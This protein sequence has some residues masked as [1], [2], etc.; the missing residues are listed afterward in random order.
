MGLKTSLGCKYLLNVSKSLV[1]GYNTYTRPAGDLA[2]GGRGRRVR[3]SRS[4][5]ATDQESEGSLD[6]HIP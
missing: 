6:I 5:L 1:A 3:N 2:H 4:P